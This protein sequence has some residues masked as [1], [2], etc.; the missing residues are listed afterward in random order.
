MDSHRAYIAACATTCHSA[1]WPSYL[2]TVGAYDRQSPRLD[3]TGVAIYDIPLDLLFYRLIAQDAH[4]LFLLGALGT[5]LHL[6]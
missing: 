4:F 3:H 6:S 1:I 5:A 2:S